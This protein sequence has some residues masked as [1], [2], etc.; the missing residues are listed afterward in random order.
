MQR[1]LLP[2]LAAIALVNPVFPSEINC[3]SPVWKNK[4][5]C[6]KKNAKLEEPKFC[7]NKNLSAIQKEE[8]LSIKNKIEKKNAKKDPKYPVVFASGTLTF[9]KQKHFLK[10][11]LF[12]KAET[13]DI[14]EINKGL[15]GTKYEPLYK[16]P[17]ERIISYKQSLYDQSDNA[18]ELATNVGITAVLFPVGA[19]FQGVNY[20][21]MEIYKWEITFIDEYGRE[22]IQTI[23]PITELPAADRYYT[24]LPNLTGLK[25]GE[26]RSEESLREFYLDGINK[27]EKK[28]EKD[29]NDLSISSESNNCRV[30]NTEEY[31]LSTNIFLEEKKEFDSL[32]KKFALEPY[33][34]KGYCN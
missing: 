25:N 20:K 34:F 6:K 18:A 26:S 31:P 3:N 5:I 10:D 30:L 9:W 27:F 12:W 7:K 19:L 28:L 17:S 24:F 29:F 33:V 14:L 23:L 21:K 13:K 8:C 22:I 16:V 15:G 1:L 11:Q 2:L 32:R 4:A